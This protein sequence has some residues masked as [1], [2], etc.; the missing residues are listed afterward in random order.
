MRQPPGPYR[1]KIEDLRPPGRQKPL[2]AGDTLR[3][4]MHRAR[5]KKSFLDRP[6]WK[7]RTAREL[8]PRKRDDTGYESKLI[9]KAIK[10]DR[11]QEKVSA[12]WQETWRKQALT[13]AIRGKKT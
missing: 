7:Q 5:R 11:H 10:K 8:W 4:K 13:S 6:D 3:A 2:L 1:G 12:R 9:Q